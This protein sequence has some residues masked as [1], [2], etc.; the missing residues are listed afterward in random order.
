MRSWKGYVH[1]HYPSS[2]CR[3]LNNPLRSGRLASDRISRDCGWYWGVFE[4]MTHMMSG[5]P[6]LS[7]GPRPQ[8]AWS[9]LGR[10]LQREKLKGPNRE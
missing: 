5:Q 6:P 7:W 4:D 8:D 3:Q 2:V 10:R 9:R 1:N